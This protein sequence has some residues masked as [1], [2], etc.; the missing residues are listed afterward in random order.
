GFITWTCP[1]TGS[2]TI[3]MFNNIPDNPSGSFYRILTGANTSGPEPGRDQ[4]DVMVVSSADG[5]AWGS[6]V[7]VNHDPPYFDNWLPEVS[8]AG[9]GR[10][11]ALWYGFHEAPDSTCGGESEIYLARSDDAGLGWIDVGRVSTANSPWTRTFS[12]I[13]PNQGDYTALY[14]NHL[15]LYAAWSDGR[16]GNPDILTL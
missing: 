11:Y 9:D 12:N 4:R 1:R 5:N 10:V 7:R 6:P 15:N 13:Q 16:F 8:V 2:Y 14:T 3:R